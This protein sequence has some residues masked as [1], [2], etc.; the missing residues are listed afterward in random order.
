MNMISKQV[1]LTKEQIMWVNAE[2][3]RTGVPGNALIRFA[4]DMYISEKE[5]GREG[6]PATRPDGE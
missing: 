1:Y 3:R 4:L 6:Q 5:R 2:S